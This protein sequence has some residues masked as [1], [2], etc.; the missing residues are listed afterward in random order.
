MYSILKN[1]Y[2]KHLLSNGNTLFVSIFF[3]LIFLHSFPV[4]GKNEDAPSREEI[5]LEREK[6]E[7]QKQRDELE[8][9][10]RSEQREREAHR[11]E[12]RMKQEVQKEAARQQKEAMRERERKCEQAERDMKNDM[13]KQNREQKDLEQ[14]FFD[15]EQKITDL[16]SKASEN[17][18]SLNKDMEDLKKNSSEN[19]QSLKDDMNEQLKETDEEIKNIEESMAQLKE[20]IDKIADDRLTAFFARR[21]QQNEFYSKCFAQ[22]LQQTEQQRSTWYNRK[23]TGTLKRKSI[24]D[25]ISGGK[26]QTKSQFS[27]KFEKLL[28]LCLNNQAALLEKQNQE[29]EYKLMLEK[30]RRQ[31]ERAKQQ[32]AG[33]QMQIQQMKTKGKADILTKFKEKM[34]AELQTFQQSYD[35]LSKNFKEQ[36]QQLIQEI[37]KVKKQQAMVLMQRSQI[38]SQDTRS[39]M[40]SNGCEMDSF[41]LFPTNNSG[42][43]SSLSYPP[44]ALK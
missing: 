12:E 35:N 25:L 31:E 21:K 44:G 22:A 23:A 42:Y 18:V 34:E 20:T 32:I 15:L 11:R 2:L 5:K 27:I 40:V 39:L 19:I 17:K 7:H 3:I 38:T 26:T 10:R 28:H 30:L 9:E 6:F 37:G 1:I 4:L 36:S 8:D 41:N 14:K 24:G 33:L 29:N 16:E 13:E 43:N